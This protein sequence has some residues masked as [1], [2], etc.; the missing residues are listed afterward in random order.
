MIMQQST[1][2]TSCSSRP[3]GLVVGLILILI[4]LIFLGFNFGWIDPALKNVILSWPMVFI[5]IGIVSF[6][7]KDYLF[8][9]IWLIAGFFFLIPRIVGSYPN[10]LPGLSS[11]FVGIYWPVLLIIVGLIFIVRVGNGK[12]SSAKRHYNTRGDSTGKELNGTVSKT[13]IFGGSESIFLEPM[14]NGGQIS[15]VFGG[16]VLDLRH[17][18]LQEG[19]TYLDIDSIFGGVE[20][21][22][23]GN[24]IVET[25]FS[26]VFGG[27]Q[28]KRLISETDSSRKLIIGG[29]LIFGGCEVR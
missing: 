21:Y 25:R 5:V 18:Q 11:D 6:S 16:A 7:K 27:Y 26:T 1:V 9:L 14:F 13:V 3:K 10:L 2:F 29:S 8:S 24:W 22:I 23:P 17:T 28:D 20:L 15:T 12:F 4:G 19:E